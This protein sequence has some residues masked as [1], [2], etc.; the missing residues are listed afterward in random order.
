MA[1][2]PA[3]IEERID[4]ARTA[5]I[6]IGGDNG[7]GISIK[8]LVDAMEVAKLISISKMAIPQFMRGEPGI[9]YAAVVRAVRW[10]ID[11]YFVAENMF[12]AKLKG[13]EEK[14]GF[15]AQLIN[16][17]I[18]LATPRILT[19]KLRCRYEGEGSELRCIVY[20]TPKGEKEPLE[21]VTPTLAAIIAHLGRNEYGKVKGSPLYDLDPKQQLWYYG[22]KNFIRRWFPEVLGGVYDPEDHEIAQMKDVTPEPAGSK[23]KELVARLQDRKLKHAK[24]TR[25]GFDADHVTREVNKAN[26]IK[27]GKDHEQEKAATAGG[28][29][30]EVRDDQG[31]ADDRGDGKPDHAGAGGVPDQSSGIAEADATSNAGAPEAQGE[32]FPP[33]RKKADE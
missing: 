12:I 4:H 2:D 9:C 23:I 7:S 3:K 26:G 30:A 22:S 32:I 17:I 25:R 21:Y 24:K 8:R 29:S 11:P 13:G 27:E 5:D 14:V 1:F 15:Q 33:D 19:G 16:S 20:G 6:E 18:N 31:N 28:G 10:G